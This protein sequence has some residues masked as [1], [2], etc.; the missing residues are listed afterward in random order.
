MSAQQAEILFICGSPRARSS[1]ALIALLEQGV[2]EAGACSRSFLL[3]QKHLAPCT[4][5]GSCEE[6][7]N[8]IMADAHSMHAA[9]DDY[10]ELMDALSLADGLAVV[11]PLYFAGPPA[12]LKA[13][14]DRMQPLWSR[15]YALGQKPLAKRP[16]QIFILGGGGDNHGYDPLVTISKSA[17]AVTGFSLEKVQNF[18][19]YKCPKEL[20]PLPSD[21]QAAEL[22]YVELARIRKETAI[23]QEFS[24]RAVAAGGAFA[25]FVANSMLGAERQAE[26][27]EAKERMG[28]Q[29]KTA[30]SNKTDES[31]GRPAK[32][33]QPSPIK[34]VSRTDSVFEA[35][36]QT[37]R[38]LR[39][40]KT[41]SPELD[42]AM[43]EA[44]AILSDEA[45]LEKSA[46]DVRKNASPTPSFPLA[47]SE[48]DV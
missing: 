27:A 1:E 2:Q 17:L 5:C 14:Y 37:A 35:L 11:T 16:A 6:T 32:L 29:V 39:A 18:I 31:E 21:E 25:R 23:Q 13:L 34:V 40:P 26:L 48:D 41:R 38:T 9:G 4:G 46:E 20:D 43:E 10:L 19:G 47:P 24:Q 3:S 8:C 7:G 22:P 33:E 30:A 36:K 15:V 45:E 44:V 42:A 28:L 12:Q